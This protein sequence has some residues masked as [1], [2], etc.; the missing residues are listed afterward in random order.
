[1]NDAITQEC[2]VSGYLQSRDVPCP[3][4]RYN[5]RGVRG[6]SCPEC[7]GPLVLELKGRRPS[8]GWIAFLFLAFGW[9]MI[10]GAINTAW[11]A[12]ALVRNKDQIA[13]LM[14]YAGRFNAITQGPVALPRLVV[15]PPPPIPPGGIPQSNLMAAKAGILL[16]S[17]VLKQVSQNSPGILLR[18][19]PATITWL[20]AWRTF[21]ASQQ[22]HLIWAAALAIGG[23]AGLVLVARF[24]RR[25]GPA[26]SRRLIW[27]ASGLFTAYAGYQVVIFGS[28]ILRI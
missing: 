7:G 13:Q 16:Q 9:V 8:S 18:T 27:A 20:D 19:P 11:S 4:C 25:D 12:R 21:G 3:S 15:A 17:Q 2:A 26:G 23:A 14:I 1:M 24:R 22:F 5:L 10:A 28:A 6:D